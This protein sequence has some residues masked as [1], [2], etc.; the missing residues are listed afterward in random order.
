MSKELKRTKPSIIK[1]LYQLSYDFHKVC[2]NA[3]LKYWMI[4]GTLLGA[5]RNKP[6]GIIGHDDDVDMGIHS[7]DVPKL[8]SLRSVF[9]HCGYK[10]VKVWFGYKICY[11]N[12]PL[13]KGEKY[14]FPNLDVFTYRKYNGKYICSERQA[15]ETWPNEWYYVE[16][17]DTL[18]KYSFGEMELWGPSKNE[19]Y[20]NRLY[21]KDWS[22][23]GYRQYDHQKEEEIKQ[24]KVRLTKE[25]LLPAEPTDQIKE[26]ACLNSSL[27]LRPTKKVNPDKY[28][29]KSSRPNDSFQNNFDINM[30]TYVINCDKHTERFSK[31]KKYAKKAKLHFRKESCVKGNEFTYNL[32]CEMIKRGLLSKKADMN[33]IEVAINLSHYNVWQRMLNNKED[34]ALVLEDDVEVHKDFVEKVNDI[35]NSLVEKEIDFNVLFLW[36]GNWGETNKDLQYITKAGGYRILQENEEYNA[37]GVAYII[38]KEFAKFLL[39]KGFPIKEPQDMFMGNFYDKGLHLTLPMKFNKKEDCYISPLL[40]MPCGGPQGTGNTTQEAD[41]PLIKQMPCKP[42]RK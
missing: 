14:S 40:N 15:R 3:N 13:V 30:G 27:C 24:V 16:E 22:F 29:R 5:V 25:D 2:R 1:L 34:Y 12:R 21:G 32:L 31:F 28:I 41:A 6:G 36:N 33:P 37:G 9:S 39:K 18:K 4:G 8:L 17:I 26:R 38:S 19:G 11:A 42:C 35:L 23:M 20:L 10:L 7:K